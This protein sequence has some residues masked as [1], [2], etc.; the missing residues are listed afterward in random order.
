MSVRLFVRVVVNL[1]VM[2]LAV[3]FELRSTYAFVWLSLSVG[4]GCFED[5][6]KLM[7]VWTDRYN[8]FLSRRLDAWNLAKAF[9][10]VF[11]EAVTRVDTIV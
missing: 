9:I 11:R 8:V 6:R 1:S 7:V 2:G 10:F 3:C 4:V 5:S